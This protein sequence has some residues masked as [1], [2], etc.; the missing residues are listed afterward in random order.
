M[1]HAQS[2]PALDTMKILTNQLLIVN[3]KIM[4]RDAEPCCSKILAV[5]LKFILQQRTINKT[6]YLISVVECLVCETRIALGY[7]LHQVLTSDHSKEN[8]KA[9]LTLRFLVSIKMKCYFS[10]LQHQLMVILLCNN[11]FIICN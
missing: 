2:F 11:M 1:H 3:K 4:Q 10:W 5:K 8:L 6:P 9:I 7:I